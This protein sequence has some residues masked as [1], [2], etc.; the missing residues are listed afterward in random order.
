MFPIRFL[1]AALV[2]ALAVGGVLG[3]HYYSLQT[4][5]ESL[6]DK[7]VRLI[8]NAERIRY[9]DELLTSSARL[10]AESG[11][12]SFES[13]YDRYESELNALIQETASLFP[14]P[15]HTARVRDTETANRRLVDMERRAFD[16]VRVGRTGEAATLLASP[17]YLEQK[18]VY[19]QGLSAALSSLESVQ[20]TRL[21]QSRRYRISIFWAGAFASVVVLLVWYF[22]IRA[23]RR[24]AIERRAAEE[25]IRNEKEFSESLIKSSVDG[26]LAFDSQCRYTIWNPAME[27]LSAL[28]A[29][30]VLGRSAFE[31]FPF[32][33]ETGDDQFFFHTLSGRPV[34]AVDRPYEIASTG[35]RGFYEA[36]YSPLRSEFGEVMGGLCVV[37]E[38]TDRKLADE[39]LRRSEEHH[40]ELFRQAEEMQE[41]LRALSL[42]IL[43]VQEEERRRISRDLHDEVGQALTAIQ[44]NLELLK[45]R[46]PEED[47]QVPKR[48][49]DTQELVARTIETVHRFCRDLRPA[50]LDDLGLVP[51]L[52]WYT[53]NFSERTG[54]RVNLRA[55]RSV[56]KL[57]HD[58][59]TLVYR[60]L[61]ESL[62]NV[63]KHAGAQ[64]AEVSI[65]AFQ[66]GISMEIRDDGKAFDVERH[67]RPHRH[68]G[69]LGLLGMQERVR[70]AKGEFTVESAM[71][72]GT[73]IRMQIPFKLG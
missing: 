19:S 8:R 34:V 31:V 13:R 63:W 35:H 57:D 7:R 66:R 16:L 36:H 44:M 25:R 48:M 39:A 27:Q 45:K 67:V 51:T 50:M 22:S 46:L 69:G 18:G 21:R 49:A 32:I 11:D 42:E 61:Q 6:Q 65:R 17:D 72:K 5:I 47:M 23:A 59:K 26:I 14:D 2:L 29:E 60:V 55:S 1:G 56:E 30:R 43:R 52:R 24:W 28:P 12:L 38:I 73:T 64:E 15:A 54:I 41:N 20:E 10:A 3:G 4:A 9:L 70:Q 37:R 68:G 71:G 33:T 40:R 58:G 62:T 53:K